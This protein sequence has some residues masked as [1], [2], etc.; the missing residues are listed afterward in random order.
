MPIPISAGARTAFALLMLALAAPAAAKA[1]EER[2]RGERTHIDLI[3]F[4][5]YGRGIGGS[6][7]A[8]L[9]GFR[10]GMRTERWGVAL[11][12]QDWIIDQP[13]DDDPEPCDDPIS[14][15]LGGEWRMPGRLGATLIVGAD[16]GMFDAEGTHLLT[17]MRLGAE[18]ALGPLGLRVEARA[19]KVLGLGVATLDA[20][21]GLRI[22]F[23]GP[24]LP[25]R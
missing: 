3:P 23:G 22:S 20:L 9:G 4:F 14:T 12:E 10:I 2:P 15:T 13:C 6:H 17:G 25:R 5:A 21:L 19:Q 24:R 8:F 7:D 16:M 18:Q 1:Q 11:T